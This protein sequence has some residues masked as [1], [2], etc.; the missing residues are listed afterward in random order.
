MPTE[1]GP[2]QTL[3]EKMEWKGA[4]DAMDAFMRKQLVNHLA[5]ATELVGVLSRKHL[6][7]AHILDLPVKSPSDLTPFTL[8][9][10]SEWLTAL[11]TITANLAT[12][13]GLKS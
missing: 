12:L 5:A 7:G 6:P 4:E 9:E 3:G 10:I 8:A 13:P 2:G 11:G 1:T